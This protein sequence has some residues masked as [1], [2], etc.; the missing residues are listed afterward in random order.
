L[1][2]PSEQGQ[3]LNSHRQQSFDAHINLRR[4]K[5]QTPEAVFSRGLLS[6]DKVETPR[7]LDFR[8]VKKMLVKYS[9][10]NEHGTLILQNA[11][12]IA[13]LKVLQ[14]IIFAII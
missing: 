12:S 6:S 1:I 10:L 13:Q 5:C 14:N 2:D 7:I 3:N 9:I 8:D 4:E 11:K